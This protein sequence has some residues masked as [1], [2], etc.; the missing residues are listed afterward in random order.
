VRILLSAFACNPQWGSEFGTGWNWATALADA[1][2]EVTVLTPPKF[3][4]SIFAAD[5]KNIEFRFVDLEAHEAGVSSVGMLR[6]AAS[7]SFYRVKPSI[8]LY[9]VYQRW[10]RR[11]LLHVQAES[12]NYDVAHHVTW[13]GLHLGSQ[14]WRMPIPF[15]YGPIGG[16]QTAP[17]AYRRYFGRSWAMEMART[18]STGP[19]LRLSNQCRQ[20]LR[21]SAVTLVCNSATGS[22]AERLGASDVRFMLADGVSPSWIGT[23]HS[24]P[25]GEPVVLF[26][27]RLLP[28]KA[29]TL[30]VEAFA[31]LRRKIPARMVIAGDGPLRSEVLAAVERLGLNDCVEMIGAV[32]HDGIKSLY[33]SS[34]VLLF[35]SLRE[36]FG[37]PLLEAL[38]RGV[39]A[40]ALNHHGV[41][42]AAVGSAAVKVDLPR[43]PDDLPRNLAAAL[44]SVICDGT[45]SARSS[46]GID[47][48]SNW[49]WAKKA[50]AAADIYREL[51]R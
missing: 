47:F 26:V 38:A 1:G 14:L 48:A 46:A 40:V 39:P 35:T 6:D 30:A 20:T 49:V 22:L 8:G 19:L 27:G 13:G 9:D 41:A 29:P 32:P 51:V 18:A 42:D 16:G 31:E 3:R 25:A 4:D 23:S 24:Q 7:A 11:A 12:H 45:W 34:T 15:I 50:A 5:P 44:E 2:H 43:N 33:D 10:Q 28:R 36:S 17:A 21:Q 37:A